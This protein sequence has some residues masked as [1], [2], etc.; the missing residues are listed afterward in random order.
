VTRLRD[1]TKF[2]TPDEV[3]GAFVDAGSRFEAL[4]M[5]IK[6]DHER[7]VRNLCMFNLAA[8]TK[9]ELDRAHRFFGE[10]ADVWAWVSRNLFEINLILR[11]IL[12]SQ[13]NLNRW[14]AEAA[15]DERDMLLGVLST[16]TE[17]TSIDHVNLVR[18][19]ISHI[20]AV[21]KRHGLEGRKPLQT[22]NLAATVAMKDEYDAFFKLYSK[23]VHPTSWLVNGDPNRREEWKGV[24]IAHAQLYAGDTLQRITTALKNPAGDTS[25]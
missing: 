6:A 18:D 5:S 1:V 14:Q 11:F 22:R 9:L 7:T 13:D 4:L 3:R 23:Y 19:R 16:A 24:L 2:G 12:Q 17:T 15:T 20:E 25:S 8:R 10:P 21:L